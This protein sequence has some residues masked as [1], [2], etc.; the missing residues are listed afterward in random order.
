M[1]RAKKVELQIQ[2]AVQK[3]KQQQLQR[4]AHVKVTITSATST[5]KLLKQISCELHMTHKE[6]MVFDS[7]IGVDTKSKTNGSVC[8]VPG[9]DAAIDNSAG[10]GPVAT[11]LWPHC[12]PRSALADIIDEAK[13]MSITASTD[14]NCDC[15][16]LS[17]C[18]C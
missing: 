18:T 10:D 17:M 5:E 11:F 13:K 4:V 14:C 8:F 2:A 6:H 15:S 9:E 1:V 12:R 16:S 7:K 3:G